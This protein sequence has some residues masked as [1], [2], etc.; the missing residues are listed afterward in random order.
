MSKSIKAEHLLESLGIFGW[1]HLV[2]PIL[3]SLAIPAPTLIYG[4]QGTAKT[5]L[6]RQLAKALGQSYQEYDS[7]KVNYES[8]AGFP[9]P[10]ALKEGRLEHISDGTSVWDKKFVM[11]DELSRAK[12]AVQ[13][14]IFEL[15][16]SRQLMGR[17][18]GVT[19]VYAAMNPLDYPG[20][21]PLDPAL[22]SRFSWTLVAP[23]AINL[24]EDDLVRVAR[25]V[26]QETLRA[27]G[28]AFGFL[29]DD[30]NEITKE[31]DDEFNRAAAY[32]RDL[33]PK[34]TRT[35]LD[36]VKQ[37]ADNGDGYVSRYAAQVIRLLGKDKGV[38]VE[39]RDANRLA[40]NILSLLAVDIALQ[41]DG[42][43]I[44]GE[45][46]AAIAEEA[47]YLSFPH[48]ASGET[49]NPN[50]LVMAHEYCRN[51]LQQAT[52]RAYKALMSEDPLEITQIISEEK[53]ISVDMET[54][55]LGRLLQAF[56]NNP[57]DNIADS[58]AKTACSLAL[59]NAALHHDAT[60]LSSDN[61]Q[62]L[63]RKFL[64][65]NS[66]KISVYMN[67]GLSIKQ[68]MALQ[69]RI[70]DPLIMLGAKTFELLLGGRKASAMDTL[71]FA[72]SFVSSF[73]SARDIIMAALAERQSDGEDEGFDSD[74][75]V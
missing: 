54:E 60:L 41:G 45:D 44:S 50:D 53:N 66:H 9:N 67:S 39:G 3:A 69:A 17:A 36:L 20:C 58:A 55:L 62:Q 32:L 18:T 23:R 72:E 42:N 73:K 28:D 15:I 43:D 12:P 61:T 25:S 46:V 22:A 30:L 6:A 26:D 37:E 63:A 16:H 34:I 5:F 31:E 74:E 24:Q 7:S 33:L 2:R 38:R 52:N 57:L 70:E 27:I 59:F 48:V 29:V 35:Y 51:I 49:I 40:R 68:A 10:A 47:L 56:D 14:M 65:I 19:W 1:G 64:A 8:L 11:F 21:N 71:R 13:N 4:E 75:Q